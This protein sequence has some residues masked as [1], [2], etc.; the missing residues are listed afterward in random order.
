MVWLI[1]IRQI[2]RRN[3]G[4][5][6]RARPSLAALRL[7][8][9]HHFKAHQIGDS[10]RGGDRDVCS[11]AAAPHDDA[12]YAGMVVTCVHSVP[13]SIEKDLKPGAE[14]HR[15]DI[16]RHADVAKITCALARRDVHAAAKRDGKMGVI[17]AYADS[18]PHR[19]A[20]ATGGTRVWVAESDLRMD[21]I[22]NGPHAA[23][24]AGNPS[25]GRPG[26]ISKVVAVAITA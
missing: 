23:V 13:A 10:K 21:K 14:V 15:V 16:N 17:A 3:L 1:L 12:A 20:G 25:E 2:C 18:L 26:E 11:V 5:H 7:L 22:A 24:T 4:S 8:V 19:I 6:M 9:G